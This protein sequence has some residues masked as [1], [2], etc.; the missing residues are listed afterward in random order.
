MLSEFVYIEDLMIDELG[1]VLMVLQRER[2]HQQKWW[3][4]MREDQIDYII[5]RSL[6]VNQ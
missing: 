6:M 2:S 4:I 1:F 5:V 3:N